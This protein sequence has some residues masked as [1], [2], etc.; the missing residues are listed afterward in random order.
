MSQFNEDNT[1]EQLFIDSLK[2]NGWKYIPADELPRD[3]TDVIVEPMVKDALIRLNPEIAEDPSRADE[4][5]YK[6]RAMLQPFPSDNLVA[7]NEAFKKKLFEENSYPFGEDGRS[8]SIS[9]FGTMTKEELAKN[10]YVVTNQWVYPSV[11]NGKR[12]DI[13]LLINGFP[14]AIGELK[15]PVRNAITWLDGAQDIAG[16][17]KS[18]PEMFVPNVF[19]FAS[20]GKCYRYGSVNMPL[21][22]W[23]P[24]H[25]PDHKAEGSLADVRISIADMLTPEKVMD[26]MQFFTLFSTDK[27]HRKIK[28][29]CRYQQ[30]EA[31]NLIVERVKENKIKQGLIW[32]FQGSGKSLL[33]VFAAQKLRMIPELQN[34]TVVIVDDRIDLETQITGDFNAADIPNLQS[35]AT[36]EE[37]M[38]FFE[39]DMR[40][41]AITTIFRFGD[42]E[43]ALNMR[44]NIILMVDEAH[45]TQEGDLGEKMRLALPNAFFFGLTGTPINRLDKN[46]FKTFGAIEDKSGYM[47]KYSFSDSIR[48]K[49]TLPLNFEPVPI[50]L[51][52]DKE[53]LNQAFDELV[54][55]LSDEDKGELS[56]MLP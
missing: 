23:G 20:E 27:K 1:V 31:A 17:E 2:K 51:H 13:V 50:D 30:Y 53:S 7:Q 12:L 16:Y 34:P 29:I 18:I 36:K 14:V 40:K 41:I 42:V 5:I 45:R 6:L 21:T 9:F 25:T 28:V 39:Q 43:K 44:D 32:H 55:G 47:S 52:V 19:N 15:T 22:K 4:V 3:T 48:D 35:L 10:E 8:T 33:M 26:I 49:A 38:N 11:D 46:T 24:W 54:D 37:L 56:K